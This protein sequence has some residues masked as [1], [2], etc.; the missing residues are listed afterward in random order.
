VFDRQDDCWFVHL[1]VSVCL[2][3]ALLYALWALPVTMMMMMAAV[4]VVGDAVVGGD[5]L[6]LEESHQM[7]VHLP[8]L[9]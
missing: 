3:H 2:Y 8:L 5:L 7:M 1:H 4:V 9:V 6:R